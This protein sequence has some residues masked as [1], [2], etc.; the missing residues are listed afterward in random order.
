MGFSGEQERSHEWWGSG[1]TVASGSQGAATRPLIDECRESEISPASG[2]PV[3]RLNGVMGS[4]P[5]HAMRQ[6][7]ATGERQRLPCQVV[8]R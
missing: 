1:Q 3:I 7:D 6:R 2:Q 4:M 5:G 8:L